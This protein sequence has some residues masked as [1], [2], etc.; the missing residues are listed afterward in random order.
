MVRVTDHTRV[1][2]SITTDFHSN[3]EFEQRGV[4]EALSPAF[5]IE[6]HPSLSLGGTV[7]LYRDS[8]LPRR[9]I[10]SRTFASFTL[11]TERLST[12]DSERTIHVSTE[13]SARS[14]TD[15]VESEPVALT[16]RSFSIP[17]L[18]SIRRQTR[19]ARLTEGTFEEISRIDDLQG[20]NATLGFLW[21]VSGFLT[22]GASV[23]LPWT[24]EAKQTRTTIHNTT[25][26]DG[27][28]TRV[29]DRSGSTNRVSKEVEFDFPLFGT[30]GAVLRWRNEFYTSLDVSYTRWSDFAFEAE[31]E[32]KINPFDGTPH[33]QHKVDDTW[34]I[35]L[36]TE[37]LWIRKRVEFPLR[38]GLIWEQRPA[39]G[40]PDD[41]F[42]FSLGSGIVLG[43]RGD[44]Q[45]LVLD[46]AYSYLTARDIQTVVPDQQGLTTD[47]EQHQV[48]VSGI[49]HF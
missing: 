38:A 18:P 48:F 14:I 15:G 31:G 34:S 30:M 43:E 35:R 5:A 6:L 8:P 23:D 45:R 20:V 46:V 11:S 28:R 49:W 17:D 7:N 37:Y 40:Q 4:I 25:T 19:E 29:L 10:R 41:Y 36:G 16:N 32:G 1:E 24:A 27:G 33:G 21:S 39:I 22:L 47:T 26:Y 2:D 42:G 3:L 13:S 12:L 44:A 9:S